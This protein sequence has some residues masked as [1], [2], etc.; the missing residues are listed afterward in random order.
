MLEMIKLAA[1]TCF[2]PERSAALP[3]LTPMANIPRNKRD[4][5]KRS[6]REGKRTPTLFVHS[7]DVRQLLPRLALVLV[8]GPQ[9]EPDASDIVLLHC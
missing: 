5:E 3:E 6:A 2:I 8:P 1:L 4:S 7:C 9:V